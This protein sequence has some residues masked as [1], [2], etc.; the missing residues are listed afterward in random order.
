[1]RDR[2]VEDDERGRGDVDM[3]VEEE[4]VHDPGEGC[5][6]EKVE[7]A[8]IAFKTAINHCTSTWCT[9]AGCS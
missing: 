6:L 2:P 4:G 9:S 7:G 5:T 8:E 3:E 1:M